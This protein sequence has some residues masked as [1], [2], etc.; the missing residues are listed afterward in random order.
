MV[1][2][3][4]LGLARKPNIFPGKHGVSKY[5]SLHMIVFQENLDCEKHLRIPF[6]TYVL[7]NN[8][9]KPMITNRTR[10]LYCIYLQ[11]TD[12]A[13]G[14]HELL[15]LQNNSVIT[16]NLVTPAPIT[17]TIINQLHSIAN[18]EGMPSGIKIDNRTGI[19]LYESAWI[20]GVDY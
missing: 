20:E 10:R 8:E 1:K 9:P 17:P 15:Q 11:A 4:G 7:A 19:V 14:V 2:Y 16:R 6:I 13:Q 12:S 5:Y 18:R 3:L